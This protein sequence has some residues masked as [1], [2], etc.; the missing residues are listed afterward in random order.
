[1]SKKERKAIAMIGVLMLFAGFMGSMSDTVTTSVVA[2]AGVGAAVT[3]AASSGGGGDSCVSPS[4]DDSSD[5]EGA[6][7]ANSNAIHLAQAFADA[8]Y[9]KAS[10]AGMLGNI[11]AESGFRPD[12]VN[13]IGATGLAQWYP[14]SKIRLA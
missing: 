5:G 14:G 11:Q 1:M 4:D 7:S 13:S 9:S 12:V 6:D 3:Q 10:T 2:G 8:G